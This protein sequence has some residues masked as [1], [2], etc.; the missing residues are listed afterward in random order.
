MESPSSWKAN[1]QR[2]EETTE[3]LY[4]PRAGGGLDGLG[5]INGQCGEGYFRIA[6][7]HSAERLGEAMTRMARFPG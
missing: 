2:I 4:N 7:T 5:S 3:I 1:F 6:L